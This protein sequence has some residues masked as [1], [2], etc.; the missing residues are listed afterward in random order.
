[1]V[2]ST[3]SNDSDSCAGGSVAVGGVFSDRQVKGDDPDVKGY[4]GPARWV[5]RGV[6]NQIN[7]KIY[8]IEKVLSRG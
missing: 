5:G 4:P 6:E 8:F 1:V 2:E 3:L 7:K